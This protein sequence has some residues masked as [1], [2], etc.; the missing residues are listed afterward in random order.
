MITNSPRDGQQ[1]TKDGIALP[2]FFLYLDQVTKDLN[3]LTAA[4][5][6]TAELIDITNPVNTDASKVL[7]YQVLNSDT[8]AT[9]FASG[10]T[11]G[12]VWHYY[13]ESTAH[14]PV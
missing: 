4:Q 11:D 9:V 3:S 6:T 2:D 5:A 8:G 13:D 14:T 12:A 1:I 7:G 10:S